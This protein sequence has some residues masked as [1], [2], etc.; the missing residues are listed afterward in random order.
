MIEMYGGDTVL[1][2]AVELAGVTDEMCLLARA[3]IITPAADEHVQRLQD[4]AARHE[5][6]S[7]PRP[8]S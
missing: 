1:E 4:D 8:A 7:S 2:R 6:R 3:W 5:L